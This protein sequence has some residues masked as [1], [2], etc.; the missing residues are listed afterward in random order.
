MQLRGQV[1]KI[2][3]VCVG[4]FVVITVVAFLTYYIVKSFS[5]NKVELISALSKYS[6]EVGPNFNSL[7][8]LLEDK[9]IFKKGIYINKD[10]KTYPVKK[11]RIILSPIELNNLVVKWSYSPENLITF[12]SA[13][14]SIA[15]ND[16]LEL[17]IYIGDNEK[18]LKDAINRNKTFNQELIRLIFYA[19]APPSPDN[20]K[21]R[22]YK[23]SDAENT[24]NKDFANSFP[25]TIKQK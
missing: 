3:L 10:S 14:Y 9:E 12:A 8:Q 1:F 17:K 16:T 23:S 21:V 25:V 11:I 5:K 13:D 22:I 20:V 7:V 18:G 4:I 24:F 6:L 19:T 15:E 2:V